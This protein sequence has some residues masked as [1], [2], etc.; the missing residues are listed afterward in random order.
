MGGKCSTNRKK[1]GAHRVLV[2]ETLNEED[3]LED[4]CLDGNVKKTVFKKLHG[5]VYCIDLG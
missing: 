5:G 3:K 2:E 1:I 4:P